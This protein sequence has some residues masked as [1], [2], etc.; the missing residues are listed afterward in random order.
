MKAQ[1]RE[2]LGLYSTRLRVY[3]INSATKRR[4][5]IVYTTFT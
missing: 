1:G 3:R 4:L 5:K 2:S